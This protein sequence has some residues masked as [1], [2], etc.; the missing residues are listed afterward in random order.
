MIE[1]AL[2]ERS[3]PHPTPGVSLRTSNPP[4]SPRAITK[5]QKRSMEGDYGP[6]GGFNCAVYKYPKRT[7]RFY[8][9]S[10]VLATREKAPR[11]W[12]LRGVALLCSTD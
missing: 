4:P 6:N 12:I 5:S 3:N 9:F 10:V 11:H 8:I 1:V 2:L 7:D